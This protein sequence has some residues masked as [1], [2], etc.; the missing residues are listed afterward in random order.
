MWNVAVEQTLAI[1]AANDY[2]CAIW[3]DLRPLR[4]YALN[5]MFWHKVILDTCR[6]LRPVNSGA[7]WLLM[8]IYIY[9]ISTF[10]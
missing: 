2:L 4:P 10:V 5:G 8:A 7:F 1:R 6:L 9:I 3:V